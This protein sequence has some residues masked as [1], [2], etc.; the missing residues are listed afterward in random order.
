VFGSGRGDYRLTV[1]PGSDSARWSLWVED[2]Y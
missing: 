2:Y 1:A